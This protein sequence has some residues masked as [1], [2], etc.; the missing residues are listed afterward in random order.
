MPTTPL[1]KLKAARSASATSHRRSLTGALNQAPVPI[2]NPWHL[3]FMEFH[4]NVGL[5]YF[6]LMA[7]MPVLGGSLMVAM[8]YGRRK[9]AALRAAHKWTGYATGS[10]LARLEYRERDRLS[11]TANLITVFWTKV[12]PDLSKALRNVS[13]VRSRSSRGDSFSPSTCAGFMRGL[14][15]RPLPFNLESAIG[16]SSKGQAIC[17]ARPAIAKIR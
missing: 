5:I 9:S 6:G 10:M 16:L 8:R 3:R 11:H 12:K 2:T 4:Q 1:P 14:P 7:A 15:P 13:A 17:V